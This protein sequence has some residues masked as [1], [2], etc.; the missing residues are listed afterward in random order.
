ML[1]WGAGF[2]GCVKRRVDRRNGAA[3]D[4]AVPACAFNFLVAGSGVAGGPV[5]A[6]FD[7]RFSCIRAGSGT[8]F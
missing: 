7:F 8:G 5:Q 6:S 3:G 2:Y 4:E 1:S